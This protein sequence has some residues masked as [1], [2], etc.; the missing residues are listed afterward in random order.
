MP[1]NTLVPLR[2]EPATT[3][4][5]RA[6]SVV[7]TGKTAPGYRR[8][9]GRRG[10]R[11]QDDHEA[12][13]RADETGRPMEG[14]AD[15]TVRWA[16]ADGRLD[17]GFTGVVRVKDE[18]RSL[19]WALPPLL[20]AARRVVLIDNGSTDGTPAVARAVAEQHGGGDRLELHHYPF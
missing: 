18:A 2:P 20:R 9:A 7:R 3:T 19:P 10:G 15:Y 4:S 16:W 12:S 6:A 17:P 13:S 1:E 14:D 8:I 5:E 11:K